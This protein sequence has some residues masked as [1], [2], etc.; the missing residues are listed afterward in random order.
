MDELLGGKDAESL[1]VF[2]E[3]GAVEGIGVLEGDKGG[4]AG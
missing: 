4:R 1:V 3:T 2:K